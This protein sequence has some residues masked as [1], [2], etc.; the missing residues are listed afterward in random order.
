[1]SYDKGIENNNIIYNMWKLI[2]SPLTI[3]KNLIVNKYVSRKKSVFDY[4]SPFDS[5]FD[6]V[7]W[8]TDD[9]LW[10]I[11]FIF[12]GYYSHDLLPIIVQLIWEAL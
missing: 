5:K 3:T 10:I 12:I 9:V 11:T 1:M 8:I 4:Y 6:S 7:Q 2:I